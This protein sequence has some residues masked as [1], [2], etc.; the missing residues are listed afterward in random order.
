MPVRVAPRHGFKPS[1]FSKHSSRQRRCHDRPK[2]PL[3]AAFEVPTFR[4][5]AFRLATVAE[6]THLPVQRVCLNSVATIH[7]LDTSD[8]QTREEQRRADG[9]GGGLLRDDAWPS[10]K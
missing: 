2:G 3:G 10:N 5:F 4:D 1:R 7:V 9:C 6:A 8:E